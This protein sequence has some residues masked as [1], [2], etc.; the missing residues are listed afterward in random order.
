MRP[1]IRAIQCFLTGQCCPIEYTW[2]ICTVKKKAFIVIV[3]TEQRHRIAPYI[4][5]APKKLSVYLYTRLALVKTQWRYVWEVKA[6]KSNMTVVALVYMMSS[7]QLY[8][9][10]PFYLL[11]YL[12]FLVFTF[13]GGAFVLLLCLSCGL[14]HTRERERGKKKERL[15]KKGR[16]KRKN[17]EH[18]YSML[19]NIIPE[20]YGNFLLKNH[21]PLL[22]GSALV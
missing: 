5:I 7:V 12:Y 13:F 16:I 22:S 3:Y 10:P 9:L 19:Q 14:V 15:K 20:N 2:A 11:F 21:L 4:C 8:L 17:D 1:Y 18:W 6:H